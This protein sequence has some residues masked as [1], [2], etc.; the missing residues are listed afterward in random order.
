M[1]LLLVR[2]KVT[3]VERTVTKK[4]YSIIPHRYQVLG[5][6]D[7]AGNTQPYSAPVQ[8]Q[9]KS[10]SPAAADNIPS[11][12]NEG[13]QVKEHVAPVKVEETKQQ[14]PAAKV[15]GRRKGARNTVRNSEN[16]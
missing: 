12:E 13:D 11:F 1:A 4:A 14:P 3:G 6:V 10:V 5:E 7:E 2:D 9:K 15:D 16:G 8:Q